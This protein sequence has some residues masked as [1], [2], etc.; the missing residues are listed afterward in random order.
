MNNHIV[1][2]L[3]QKVR[4][5]PVP[6]FSMLPQHR[7]STK[8]TSCHPPSTSLCNKTSPSPPSATNMDQKS[9]PR[10]S[11][12]VLNR[13]QRSRNIGHPIKSKISIPT[14]LRGRETSHRILHEPNMAH[15][16]HGSNSPSVTP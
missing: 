14:D 11:C 7:R 8:T 16:H 2:P 10:T 5:F 13:H 3:H 9:P 4:L 15:E 12:I 1:V 6:R